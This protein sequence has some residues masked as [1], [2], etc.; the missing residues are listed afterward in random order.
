MKQLHTN[1]ILPFNI[2]ILKYPQIENLDSLKDN[3]QSFDSACDKICV[4]NGRF[5]YFKNDGKL[6]LYYTIK[7]GYPIIK[8]YSSFFF[9]EFT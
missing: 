1:F 9:I 3:G 8:N 4:G 5:F 6:D 2:T 7:R